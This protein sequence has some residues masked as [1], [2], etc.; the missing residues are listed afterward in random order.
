MPNRKVGLDASTLTPSWAWTRP[1]PTSRC[2]RSVHAQPQCGLGRVHSQPQCG[3][4]RVHAQPQPALGLGVDHPTPTWFG[5]GC[6]EVDAQ[7]RDGRG[8]LQTQLRVSVDAPRLLIIIKIKIII[9]QIIFF[10]SLSIFLNK[11]I[12]NKHNYNIDILA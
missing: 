3:R 9:T 2:A 5:V 11:C 6:G 1:R 12:R 7:L 10:L 4:G 8:R